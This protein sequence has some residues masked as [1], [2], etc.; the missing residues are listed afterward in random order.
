MDGRIQWGAGMII[1]FSF[2]TCSDESSKNKNT[3]P[4]KITK[5][6]NDLLFQHQMDLRSAE[7]LQTRRF[8]QAA[9]RSFVDIKM[10]KQRDN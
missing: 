7:D 5:P 9:R 10:D 6:W 2:G 8:L 4:K 3:K 1:F